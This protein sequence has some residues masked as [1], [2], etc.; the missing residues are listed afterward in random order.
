MKLVKEPA[1]HTAEDATVGELW[2]ASLHLLVMLVV[3][4]LLI[5]PVLRDLP[6]GQSTRT[7][8][9]AWLLVA[10]SLYWLYRGMGYQPLLLLQLL[11]FSGAAALLSLKVLL[12]AAD[13]H[14]LSVLRRVAR[15]LIMIGAG[16]AGLNLTAMLTTLIRRWTRRTR[17]P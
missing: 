10:L 1:K 4:A 9:L 17:A 12:V 16:L 13:V 14:S 11:I 7:G 3:L 6:L 2:R 8:L 15:A 5:V